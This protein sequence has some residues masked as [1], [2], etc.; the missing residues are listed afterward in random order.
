MISQALARAVLTEALGTGGDFSE[1]FLEDTESGTIEMLD[2]GVENAVY[3][4]RSG[5]GVRVFSGLASAYAH[6]ADLSEKALLATARAA[7]AA[8]S[9]AKS[10]AAAVFSPTPDGAAPRIPFSSID[11]AAR[12]RLLRDGSA[13]AKAYSP[14]VTKVSAVYKDIDR[15]ILVANSEGVFAGDRQCRTRIAFEAVASDGKSSQ[16][17]FNGPGRGMGFEAYELIDAAEAGREAA[18]VAVTMLHAPECPAGVMP[19]V[20]SGGFGGVIFH[21]ACGHSLEATAVAKGNS[22]FSG[23]MGERIANERVTAVDD[24]TIPGAWGSYRMDDEGNPGRRTVLIEK[25]ILRSY[26]VDRF[27]ARRMGVP[28]TGCARRQDYGFAPT[29]RM[30][31]T[32]IQAGEDD[33]DEM[34]RT[35]GDGLY[36]RTMGGGSVNPITGEFNFSVAEGYWV[37]NGA[38]HTP[39]RG[40]A[41]IGK[42]GEIL[43][44]IDRV[45]S[46]MWLAEGMCGSQSGSVPVTVGQPQ[47]RV[48]RIT[49]GGKGGSL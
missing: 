19:V 38:L 17:G 43:L 11:N 15:R 22:E 3:A 41:L 48:S 21:E 34:L 32:F 39:V 18:R 27:G 12:I 47:L 20:L 29:S 40:A 23:K 24:A 44:N 37:K 28:P 49:V 25:G 36:A 5:A 33:E 1:L 7:A 30:S 31:N 46:R 10:A 4:R 9:G 45:G 42:G 8:L 26:L 2:S 35:M 16:T 14:E 13:A 6:T